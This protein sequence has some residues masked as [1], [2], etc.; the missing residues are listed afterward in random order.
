[1]SG[2][3]AILKSGLFVRGKNVRKVGGEDWI[4]LSSMSKKV[5]VRVLGGQ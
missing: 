4:F 5:R 1:V 2:A 3:A